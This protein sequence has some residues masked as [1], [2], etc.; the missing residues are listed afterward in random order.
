MP[1]KSRILGPV[2]RFIRI[3]LGQRVATGP[4]AGM[5]YVKN[6]RGSAYLPK[7]LG[8][9]EK[10]L[11]P[12][13]ELIA[14]AC[15][16][17]TLI[18]IGSAEGYY[19]I[20]ALYSGAF[21]RV[22]CYEQDAPARHLLEEMALLNGVRSGLEINAHCDPSILCRRL[23]S[24]AHPVAILCDVEGYENSL[25]DPGT[26]ENLRD[27]H[28][29]IEL[30]EGRCPGVKESLF[31]RFQATHEIQFIPARKRTIE[32]LP[33]HPWL[34]GRFPAKNQ[35]RW[36]DELRDIDTPWYYMIPRL[37]PVDGS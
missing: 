14:K 25:L 29:L 28:L 22:I 24:V 11:W 4:F 30:H 17:G 1:E 33:L 21:N 26:I 20:G 13:W 34:L 32:D 12:T 19:A 37:A 10:E 15:R 18:N 8:T 6:S 5:K 7:L 35:L 3:L 27:C 16:N 9:Y 31:R 36:L 2:G 23:Q